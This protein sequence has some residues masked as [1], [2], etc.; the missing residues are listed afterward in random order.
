MEVV[1]G[2]TANPSP[3]PHAG[4]ARSPLWIFMALTPTI[5][6]PPKPLDVGQEPY[7]LIGSLAMMVLGLGEAKP[8]DTSGIPESTLCRP[9][10]ISTTGN[11]AGI[12]W[13]RHGQGLSISLQFQSPAGLNGQTP[14]PF[15]GL[16]TMLNQTPCSTI[17]SMVDLKAS[18]LFTIIIP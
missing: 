3:H 8:T 13:L 10:D 4:T 11:G 15:D 14:R 17:L 5:P 6:Q 12:Y 16:E 9:W 2:S 7:K 1:S 18:I